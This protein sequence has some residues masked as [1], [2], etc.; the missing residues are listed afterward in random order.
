[1]IFSVSSSLCFGIAEKMSFLVMPVKPNSLK[2]KRS[3][4]TAQVC[5]NHSALL[6]KSPCFYL[7]SIILIQSQRFEAAFY[8]PG[9]KGVSVP[10]FWAEPSD[11]RACANM[12]PFNS[13]VPETLQSTPLASV[14]CWTGSISYSLSVFWFMYPLHCCTAV[15]IFYQKP[16]TGCLLAQHLQYF[17]SS[18]A[19]RLHP[20]RCVWLFNTLQKAWPDCHSIMSHALSH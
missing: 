8:P 20:E 10:R 2:T 3:I 13:I 15:L 19:T 16:V 12:P 1:M 9:M 7:I 4:Q 14:I 18:Q 5:G 6:G 11:L 17:K